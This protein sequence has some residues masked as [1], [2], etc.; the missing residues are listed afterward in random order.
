MIHCAIYARVSTEKQ[1]DSVEHQVSLLTEFARGR[2]WEVRE[3]S[4]Y[5]DEGLS[6]TSKALW[7]RPSMYR[8]L[9][10]AEG[11]R[12]QVVLFKGISRLARDEE[13]AIGT[14]NR[15]KS[16]G[17]RIISLE[18]NYDSQTT[19]DMIFTLHASMAKYEAEKISVR[20]RL[21]NIEKAKRGRW[22]SGSCPI[23]Y[24]IR[25]GRLERDP[26]YAPVVRRIFD[27]YLGGKGILTIMKTLNRE[28]V[29][30]PQGAKWGNNTISRMLKNQAYA[31][32]LIYNKTGERV[33]REYD[34]ETGRA[35]KRRTAVPK[36]KEEWVVVEGAHDGIVSRE[37]FD[38]VQRIIQSRAVRRSPNKQYP[39]SGIA[40][41]AKCGGSLVAHVKK[42]NYGKLYRYYRCFT[43][44]SQ[45]KAVCE[46]VSIAMHKLNG[47]VQYKLQQQLSAIRNDED[48]W[49]HYK[50]ND[51][52]ATTLDRQMK[53]VDSKIRSLQ[54]DITD[55]FNQRSL[56]D[57]DT[58]QK[59]LESK[60]AEIT[61]LKD[62]KKELEETK[63][64]AMAG[65]DKLKRIRDKMDEFFRFKDME[66]NPEQ[67]RDLFEMFLDCVIVDRDSI[68]I[69]YSVDFSSFLKVEPKNFSGNM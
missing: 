69:H 37:E 53:S 7:E 25:D 6:A 60:K 31:G 63:A 35:K 48:F 65:D 34:D 4:I 22:T 52:L 54:K 12:F 40:K 8:L 51:L 43:F 13:E 58:Y 62:Q 20:V 2:G 3:D 41:C 19:P 55:L 36:K 42:N 68:E 59:I 32:T 9:K 47:I 27:M 15:L 66:K 38:K 33:I 1:G 30:T 26:E 29:R 67:V 23:G 39:L 45:G 50:E 46:G 28:G 57:E 16:K 11:G 21:G 64:Q 5:E 17:L 18:E 10:D 44:Q 14:A 61:K 49:K 24:N 56:F